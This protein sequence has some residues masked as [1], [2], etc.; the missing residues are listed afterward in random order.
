VRT[1]PEPHA[2]RPPGVAAASTPPSEALAPGE[3]CRF[4]RAE[5]LDGL[6][7]LHATFV[8]H[9][10]AP[11]THDGYA[12]GVID[13][14]VEHFRCGGRS[15]DAPAGAVVLVNPGAVHTGHSLLPGGFTYRMLYPEPRAIAAAVSELGLAQRGA[16]EF[17]APVVFD[18]EAAAR[19][20]ALHAVFAR[21]GTTLE[22]QTRLLELATLLVARHGEARADPRQPRPERHA[23]RRARDYLEAHATENVTLGELAGHVGLSVFHLVRVFGAE[24]GMPPHA[25]HVELRVRQARELLRRG[26]PPAQVAVELGFVDQSHLTREFKRRVGVTPGR[27]A[28]AASPC[29]T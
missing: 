15:H 21:P 11:H 27:Y 14:G 2:G 6:E 29:K 12:V 26:L 8:R 20:R 10:F 28:A 16:L 23:V 22:R 13:R 18:P 25:W 19:V 1:G 3:V 17:P 7:L 24:M 4:W 5:E 9:S